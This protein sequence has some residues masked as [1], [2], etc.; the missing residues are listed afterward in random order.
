M[1]VQKT[2]L[3]QK[4]HGLKYLKTTLLL[5]SD[6]ATDVVFQ[7][8]FTQFSCSRVLFLYFLL[9]LVSALFTGSYLLLVNF[10]KKIFTLSEHIGDDD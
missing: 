1:K 4:T 10:P 2:T 6:Y 9:F 7:S 3:L 8:F 5:L